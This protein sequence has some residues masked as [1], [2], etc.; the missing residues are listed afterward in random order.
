M[1]ERRFLAERRR[2]R[3]KIPAATTTAG[4]ATLVLKLER[5]GPRPDVYFLLTAWLY[6]GREFKK[7]IYSNDDPIEFN[8]VKVELIGILESAFRAARQLDPD[9]QRV[10]LEFAVP[11]TMLCCPF[12]RWTFTDSPY[13]LLGK[14]FVVVVRDLSASVD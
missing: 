6:I 12:E 1:A 4:R 2:P 11:R 13:A 7:T 10:D 3:H 8:A 5:S 9:E 14:K